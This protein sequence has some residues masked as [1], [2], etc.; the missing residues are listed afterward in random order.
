MDLSSLVNCTQGDR[1]HY[2]ANPIIGNNSFAILG[3]VH[4]HGQISADSSEREEKE[5]HGSL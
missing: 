2:Y 1:G 4:V 5:R 3:D